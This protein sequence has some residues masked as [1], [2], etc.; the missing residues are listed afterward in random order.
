MSIPS[1]ILLFCLTC[2]LVSVASAQDAPAG[3]SP[4][5]FTSETWLPPFAG[6]GFT[7]GGNSGVNVQSMDR[8]FFIQRGETQL[9]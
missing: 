5:Q 7:W 6:P 2:G 4:Y 3:P 9:P 1:R 8:I